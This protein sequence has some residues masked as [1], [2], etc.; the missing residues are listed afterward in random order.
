MKCV[1]KCDG[2]VT[3][4]GKNG[5]LVGGSLIAGEKL[6]ARTIGSPMGTATEIQVG[7]NPKEL[8]RHKDKVEEFNKLKAEFE[9]CEIAIN[10]LS[11]LKQKNMLTED[12]KALLLK[13]LSSKMVMREKMSKLQ[14]EID[15][16]VQVLTSN[17]GSV[18]ASKVIRPGVRVTIGNA[19]LAVRDEIQNCKLWNNGAKIAIG[20]NV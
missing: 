15:E 4:S 17:T 6:S 9:K 13:M 12:K 3:L 20:P 2:D 1:V 19:Q 8:T 16:L 10:T 11:N 7:G 14:D 18:R 5:L